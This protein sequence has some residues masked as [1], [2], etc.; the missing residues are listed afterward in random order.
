MPGVSTSIGHLYAVRWDT[1]VRGDFLMVTQAVRRLHQKTGKPVIYIAIQ[2]D[3]YRDPSAEVFQELKSQFGSFIEHCKA[4]YVLI[5]ATG[6]KASLQRSVLKAALVAGRT[7]KV[8]GLD[9]VFVAETLDEILQ[10]EAANLPAPA[11]VIREELLAKGLLKGN[12]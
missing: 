12:K 8:P 2:D 10:R 4:D 11:E 1:I 5:V 6:V 7:A 3:H 9:R